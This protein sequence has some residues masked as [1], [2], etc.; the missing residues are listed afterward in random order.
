MPAIQV[1]RTDTF[2][3]QRQKINQIGDQIFSISQGGSDLSTGNLKLGDGAID[4]PSLAF[5]SDA[6]LGIYKNEND[7]VGFVTSSKKIFDYT[8]E[9]VS[10]YKDTFL[11][12]RVLDSTQIAI[13]S[14]GERY[15]AGDYSNIPL[16]GGAGTG[17]TGDF[18]IIEFNGNIT[19]Q[20]YGY[21][22]GDYSDVIMN[23]GSSVNFT[24][25]RLD[26]EITNAGSGYFP[27]VF[28]GVPLIY[29]G[30]AGSGS[31]AT[32]DLTFDGAINATGTITN[33][34]SGYFEAT[35]TN[36]TLR[37][38][39][40]Q[41]FAITAILNPGT[42]PPNSVYQVD[43]SAQPTLT[44]T[45]GNTYRFDISDSSNQGHSFIVRA[46]DGNRSFLDL[47]Y[48]LE[49]KSGIEGTAGAYVDL[50]IKP[51]APLGTIIYDCEPHI[52]M[53]ATI[54]VIDGVAGVYGSGA[55]A[56]I[57]VDAAGN[58]V[59][60]DILEVGSGYSSGNQV[61]ADPG[62]LGGG[63][64]FLY[65]FNAITYTGTLTD[66]TIDAEGSG[67]LNGETLTFDD[68]NVGG[69]GGAGAVITITSN[70]STV[71][72]ISFNERD[73]NHVVGDILTFNTGVSNVST[74]LPGTVTGVSTFLS[75]A[76]T[77]IT[78]ASTTGILAGMSVLIEAGSDGDLAV[79]TTVQQVLGGTQ[80]QLSDLPT[81]DGAATLTFLSPDTTLI[82]VASIAGINS[83]DIVT[84][85][86]GTGVI[87]PGTTVISVDELG[88]GITLSASPLTAGPAVL[89][90]EPS[91]GVGSP[92]FQY[93]IDVIG[94]VSVFSINDGG[95]GYLVNDLL[96][97][98]PTNLVQPT[99]YEVTT[100]GTQL[101][102]LQAGISSGT[103]S[104][105]DTI[106]KEPGIESG[107]VLVVNE[108]AGNIVS[109]LV[110]NITALDDDQISVNGGATLYTITTA[111]LLSQ[112]YFV[113]GSLHPNLTL[114]SGNFYQFDIS[115]SSNSTS[116][117]SFSK[118]RD[119]NYSPSDISNITTTL[120]TLS[121]VVV[122]A[123]TAGILPD[124][125]VV[126]VAGD[127]ALVNGTRV[128]S[129]DSATEITLTNLPLVGG[130]A[131]LQFFG[132]EY[133]DGVVR[134][135][136]AVTIKISDATPSP[137][138]YYSTT[139]ENY[140]GSDLQE[141]QITI[142]TN[143]PKVFGSGFQIR[144][145]GITEEN[146]VSFNVLDGV[147]ESATV[148]S[149]DANFATAEVTT[150]LT[151]PNISST[152]INVDRVESDGNLT[153]ASTNVDIL[154]GDLRLSNTLTLESSSGD[155]ASSGEIKTVGTFNSSDKLIINGNNISSTAG[156]D[157]TL[158]PSANRLTKVVS[159]GAF[160]IPVGNSDDR[161]S[162]AIAEDGAIRFNTETNQYEGYSEA[163]TNWSS[164]G[165]VRDIDGNTYI[166]AEEYAQA[167]DNTLWFFNDNINT[168]K[169]T[170][171]QLQ[172]HGAKT[173]TSVNTDAP[174]WRRWVPNSPTTLGEYLRYRN[175]IYEVTTAGTTGTSGSEPVHTSG[176]LVNG[177]TTLT[178]YS[179]AVANLVFD[180]IEELRVGPL[181]DLPLVVNS[182]LKLANNVIS[183]AT[184]DIVIYPSDGKKVKIQGYSSLVVPIGTEN[185]KGSP[186]QGSIRYN[187]TNANFEGFNGLTWGSLG[188]VKDVD[189]NTYIIPE[190][191]PGTN[192]NILYFYND[193]IN[194]INVT[195]NFVEFLNIDTVQSSISDE[196][197]IEASTITIDGVSTVIDNT[198]SEITSFESTKRY[199]DFTM[200]L[201]LNS[202]PILRLENTGDIFYNTDYGN[203]AFTG[204]K[205]L[206]ND[207]RNL[208]L[209]DFKL[210]TTDISL[211]KGTIDSSSRTI[212]DP[213][214][215]V[216]AKVSVAANNITTGEKEFVE[217]SV[218]DNGSDIFHTDF[219][220]IKSGSDAIFGYEFSFTEAG[221]VRITLTSGDALSNDDDIA[222]V[223]TSHI[224]KK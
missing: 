47:N 146:T 194:T 212:Y 196:L 173:I 159:T 202:D 150:L 61:D 20:G 58:V 216:G 13:I 44:L 28:F 140:G 207:L 27:G 144:A 14:F 2:E 141:A 184:Q 110:E 66:I 7:G 170:T 54:N 40:T 69:A 126:V 67:Y 163:T 152:T 180:E 219:G 113:D 111:G 177:T 25:D 12:K 85:S 221:A 208:E 168:V 31:N 116:R 118:F 99:V 222:I 142:D 95:N 149:T 15:D 49:T 30:A 137:L 92:A 19:N 22:S 93:E 161:P 217:F 104:V 107:E 132:Y 138:Y 39:P 205:L 6:K 81:L 190:L 94:P 38:I 72:L 128:L 86:S 171:T 165:G 130:E 178:W 220:N 198:D 64:G 78:V 65:T 203:G 147:V 136:G 73:S 91:Y 79:N 9:N 209:A 115:D 215:H 174:N 135:D 16:T 74:T 157:I 75:T 23:D 60:V 183:S 97:V 181:G 89:N 56:D 186:E 214:V 129:V 154:S 82:T 55:T 117:F 101:L 122:V 53:G 158:T 119:G 134:T 210:T 211:R 29:S 18:N 187:T 36:V 4:T 223:V 3:L 162:L 84:Q 102:T 5:T 24:V 106:N 125:E 100:V 164:L 51:D 199:L 191:G 179:R 224:Y 172:F 124:M 192:E 1:S 76:S 59:S 80:I 77:T 213:A 148:N 45:R 151:A 201:G 50:V 185:N 37:N 197:N 35:Y 188:G 70:P 52:G 120:S 195:R 33:P 218:I 63:S 189:Q 62:S 153:I 87:A 48:Y 204:I 90:F 176:A 156:N 145:A 206:D 10:F 11:Q 200:S 167:N 43:G 96:S 42:P 169:L 41:T 143:N 182:Q 108:S 71:S 34:G 133:T 131:T 121:S 139:A 105:G 57:E 175:N 127:G 8:L 68:A 155:I 160:V 98:D 21:R 103:I 109:I 32:A 88:N 114:Y 26:V 123:S 17:A 46:N 83:G 166:L 193:N 112:R